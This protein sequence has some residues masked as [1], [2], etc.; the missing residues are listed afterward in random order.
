MDGQALLH[1][2]ARQG[3]GM[4]GPTHVLL[5]P[6]HAL[7]RLEIEPA[8]IEADA[9]ADEHELRRLGIAPRGARSGGRAGAGAAHGVDGGKP[10]ES[11]SS[12]TQVRRSH[13]RDGRVRPRPRRVPRAELFRRRVDE[14]AQPP[15]R[16]K[17]P[18]LFGKVL[19]ACRQARGHPRRLA[20]AGVAIS[21]E[22][23]GEDSA[24]GIGSA[25][26][27]IVASAAAATAKR[28]ALGSSDTTRRSRAR[29]WCPIRTWQDQETPGS[30][31]KPALREARFERGEA[32]RHLRPFG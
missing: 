22:A 19:F 5:H 32:G 17:R 4:G 14:I 16:A 6:A 18:R 8:R 25:R 1:H 10:A 31:R 26:E 23:P 7:G 3:Q 21:P 27:P 2:H 13:P 15:D 20:V 12:P 24:F 29:S 9:L 30:A 28:R 11:S